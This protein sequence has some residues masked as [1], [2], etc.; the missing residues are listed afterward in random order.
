MDRRDPWTILSSQ[1]KDFHALWRRSTGAAMK[2]TN[3][4]LAAQDLIELLRLARGGA[5]AL[6]QHLLREIAGNLIA[7]GV[8][9]SRGGC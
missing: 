8:S 5:G 2:E 6:T 3:M 4:S 9:D 7:F 1:Q